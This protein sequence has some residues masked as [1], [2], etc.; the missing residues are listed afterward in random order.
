MVIC[1]RRHRIASLADWFIWI[2]IRYWSAF[3]MSLRSTS[4]SPNI[5]FSA[6]VFNK[7]IHFYCSV[8]QLLG[9]RH[10]VLL[11]V[12]KLGTRPI[13]LLP[14]SKYGWVKIWARRHRGS[15]ILM[16]TENT[17]PTV[18]GTCNFQIMYYQFSSRMTILLDISS[19]WIS[20]DETIGCLQSSYWSN[21]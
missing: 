4:F 11:A 14:S 1:Q 10:T 17:F 7:P 6:A 3:E 16:H 9:A 13:I 20:I 18:S 5:Y 8:F 19:L 21:K 15:F 12:Y 2:Y